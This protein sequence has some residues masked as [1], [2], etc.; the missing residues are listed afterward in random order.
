MAIENNRWEKFWSIYWKDTRGN[1]KQY[2]SDVLWPL[3]SNDLTS[4]F[5]INITRWTIR[6]KTIEKLFFTSCTALIGQNTTFWNA[7]RYSILKLNA[8]YYNHQKNIVT[9]DCNLLSV[10]ELFCCFNTLFTKVFHACVTL[11]TMEI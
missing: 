1:E 6:T 10:I 2:F 11:V 3:N 4:L 9:A 7:Y 8:V 5:T